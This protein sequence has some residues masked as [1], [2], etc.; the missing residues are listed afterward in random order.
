[1]CMWVCECV[2]HVCVCVWVRV[3]VCVCAC[4]CVSVSV[5]CVCVCV[6]EGEGACVC[7]INIVYVIHFAGTLFSETGKRWFT[8]FLFHDGYAMVIT[9]LHVP[10]MEIFNS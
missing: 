9:R 6:G 3:R 10:H 2:R 8:R 4:G 1:M 5:T 7:A